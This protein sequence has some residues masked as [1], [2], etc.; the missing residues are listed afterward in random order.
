MMRTASLLAIS[1]LLVACGDEPSTKVAGSETSTKPATNPLIEERVGQ[2]KIVVD[3][4][5]L[6]NGGSGPRTSVRFGAPRAEV[7]AL[8]EKALKA[9]GER[10]SNAECG[11]GAMDFTDIGPLQIAYQDGK[12][13]GWYLDDGEGVATSDGVVPGMALAQLKEWRM[14]RVITDSTLEGE[15]EYQT[16]DGGMITGFFEGS[17][18]DGKVVALQAGFNCFFR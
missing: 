13:V 2:A 10:S 7:D 16:G 8:V 12:F 14:V 3:A 18:D 6:S 4:N 9:E 5:G 1:L 17:Q 11:A 15:F